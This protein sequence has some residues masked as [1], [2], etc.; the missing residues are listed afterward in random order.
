MT[1]TMYICFWFPWWTNIWPDLFFF[2]FFYAGN[3]S[4]DKDGR[5]KTDISSSEM[6]RKSQEL[7]DIDI[8]ALNRSYECSV[9]SGNFRSM[10]YLKRHMSAVHQNEIVGVANCTYCQFTCKTPSDLKEH[11]DQ[12]H[13][14]VCLIC[15]KAFSS[16]SGFYS[17]NRIHHGL[18]EDLVKCGI[19]GKK[20]ECVSRLRIHERSHSSSRSF[21]CVVCKRSYKHKY[22]LDNHVCTIVSDSP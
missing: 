3:K 10:V 22:S 13:K 5:I 19:C 9:C 7:K 11:C 6:L 2:L 12:M 14:F 21:T 17:H 4:D 15:K 20:F 8:S 1:E 16:H 18:E